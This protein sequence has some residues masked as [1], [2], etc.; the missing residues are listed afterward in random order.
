MGSFTVMGPGRRAATRFDVVSPRFFFLPMRH[1][2]FE[3]NRGT[4]RIY[5][6]YRD[7]VV[8]AG[9]INQEEYDYGKTCPRTR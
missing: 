9:P 7:R 2:T 3:S 6:L 5:L 4:G 8:A 1:V